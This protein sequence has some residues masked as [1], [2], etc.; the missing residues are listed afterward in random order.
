[1]FFVHI[2]INT[3]YTLIIYIFKFGQTST[4]CCGS[5]AIGTFLI[6]IWS[7]ISNLSLFLQIW[8]FVTGT[9]HSAAL[10]VLAAN[11]GPLTF[12]LPVWCP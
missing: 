3:F 2:Q 4:C 12:Y 10:G 8:T 9:F 7:F 6:R 5:D 1:M 11:M